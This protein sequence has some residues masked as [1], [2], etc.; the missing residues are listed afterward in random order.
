MLVTAQ[1]LWASFISESYTKEK[2]N[3]IPFYWWLSKPTIN[4]NVRVSLVIA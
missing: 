4:N 3:L 2:P 1:G